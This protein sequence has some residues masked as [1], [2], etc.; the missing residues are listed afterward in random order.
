MTSLFL[1]AALA[2]GVEDKGTPAP[3][4]APLV[5]A[6]PAVA[7]PSAATCGCSVAGCDCLSASRT[8][9]K[10]TYSVGCYSCPAAVARAQAGCTGSACASANCAGSACTAAA[11]S[12]CKSSF[13]GAGNYYRDPSVQGC[14]GQSAHKGAFWQRSKVRSRGRGCCG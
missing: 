9:V 12:S 14:G 11:S 6:A 8:K 10:A 2:A 3:A 1:F 5:K 7:T 4:P 13:R